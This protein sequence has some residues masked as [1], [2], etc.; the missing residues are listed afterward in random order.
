MRASISETISGDLSRG[1][2]THRHGEAPIDRT[3]AL[4]HTHLTPGCEAGIAIKRVRANNRPD[5][6]RQAVM[7]IDEALLRGR[8]RE[9]VESINGVDRLILAHMQIEEWLKPRCTTCHG[10]RFLHAPGMNRIDCEACDASGLQRYSDD[11]RA[12]RFG[13]PLIDDENWLMNAVMDEI[14]HYDMV[15]DEST[16]DALWRGRESA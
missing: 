16:K 8:D 7:A 13:R 5:D 15:S 4:A 1:N 3:M 9:R 12:E 6:V 10:R 2:Q 14:R 11:H